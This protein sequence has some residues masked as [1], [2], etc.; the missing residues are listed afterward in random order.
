MARG[1]ST[2]DERQEVAESLIGL[3]PREKSIALEKLHSDYTIDEWKDIYSRL[4]E[5]DPQ[6]Q[7]RYNNP[8]ELELSKMSEED[9]LNSIDGIDR[10]QSDLT[11]AE[12]PI[13]KKWIREE[14][15]KRKNP[16]GEEPKS[17]DK[18]D[19]EVV[20]DFALDAIKDNFTPPGAKKMKRKIRASDNP[21]WVWDN[22]DIAKRFMATPYLYGNFS[23]D[24]SDEDKAELKKSY[25]SYKKANIDDLMKSKDFQPFYEYVEEGEEVEPN[26]YTSKY[27]WGEDESKNDYANLDKLLDEWDKEDVK[28]EVDTN[29]NGKIEVD[30][31][32]DFQKSLDDYAAKNKKGR[33]DIPVTTRR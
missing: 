29:D 22:E 14:L 1:N 19:Y 30:E 6:S 23:K 21:D 5:N 11:D 16:K 32:A 26:N 31:M 33:D 18:L 4:M 9:L 7:V 25:Q 15:K 3:S 12:Q 27:L 17:T 10:G 20:N 28:E 8:E 13:V 2:E 24:M